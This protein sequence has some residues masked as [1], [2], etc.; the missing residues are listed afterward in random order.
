MKWLAEA[1]KST[2]RTQELVRL[3]RQDLVEIS[4]TKQAQISKNEKALSQLKQKFLSSNDDKKVFYSLKDI[5]T[6][7]TYLLGRR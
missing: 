2:A 1:E 5:F 4:P 6:I 7:E 3:I